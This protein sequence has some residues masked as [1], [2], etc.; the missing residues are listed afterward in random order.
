MIRISILQDPIGKF[1]R[2]RI[3]GHA[4]YAE[5]GKDIVCAAVSGISIG[6]INAIEE[7]LEVR[8]VTDSVHAGELDVQV[9]SIRSAEVE[10]KVQLLLEAMIVAL[11]NVADEYPQF[12]KMKVKK[13]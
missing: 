9:P 12:V 2:I 11:R 8:L 1:Q 4:D 7:L 13:G 10:S 5:H 6:M 3:E